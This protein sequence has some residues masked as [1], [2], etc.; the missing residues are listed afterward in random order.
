MK[1]NYKLFF[2]ISLAFLFISNVIFAQPQIS[3]EPSSIDFGTVHKNDFIGIEKIVKITNN[4]SAPLEIK[5]ILT[6]NPLKV[7]GNFNNSII[8]AGK[9]RDISVYLSPNDIPK[10]GSFVGNL[11]ITHSA[12]GSP[13]KIKLSGKAILEPLITIDLSSET[14]YL[15]FGGVD[16]GSSVQ[17]TIMIYNHSNSPS[18]MVISSINVI[19]QDSDIDVKNQVGLSFPNC[20][21]PITISPGS[22]HEFIVQFSPT[23][24]S[25]L[26]HHSIKITYNVN[27]RKYIEL[28]GG[29][30]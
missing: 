17:K 18:N 11:T 30:N 21:L 15:S 5:S 12:S 27:Y 19:T 9:Y 23:V 4:G 22:Y 2:F 16:I 7:Y 28:A 3:V 29:G 1:K 13:T 26:Y 20:K 8:Q 25:N 6:T 10:L 24:T 14:H